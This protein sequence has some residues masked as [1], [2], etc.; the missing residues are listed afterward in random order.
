[1]GCCFDHW[2]GGCAHWMGTA[3]LRIGEWGY[4]FLEKDQIEQ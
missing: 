2:Q 1:M 4:I 3:V